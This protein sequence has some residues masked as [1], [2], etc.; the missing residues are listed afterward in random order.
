MLNTFLTCRLT[1]GF[2]LIYGLKCLKSYASFIDCTVSLGPT[3]VANLTESE[4]NLVPELVHWQKYLGLPSVMLSVTDAVMCLIDFWLPSFRSSSSSSSSNS[5]SSSSSS[6]SS[7]DSISN[8]SPEPFNHSQ[9]A[10]ARKLRTCLS[11]KCQNLNIIFTQ[12]LWPVTRM[13][14]QTPLVIFMFEGDNLLLCNTSTLTH[15]GKV[16]TH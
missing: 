3:S 5:N 8:S 11:W 7:K 16:T 9:W 2:Q 15:E 14:L 13:M 6:S 12:L 4:E 1:E 10:L